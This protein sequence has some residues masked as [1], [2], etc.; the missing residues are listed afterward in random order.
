VT[1]SFS[2]N[3]TATGSSTLTV[4]ASSSASLGQYTV[5]ITGRSGTQTA[6]TTVSLG[7]Y[8]PTFTLYGPGNVTLDQG[9]NTTSYVQVSSEYGFTGSV[10]F[11]ISGLPSGVTASF[12]PNPT[13]TGTSVLTLQANSS[14][15]LGQQHTVTIT[16]TSGGQSAST[17][18]SLAVYAPTFTIYSG[19]NL[20]VGRGTSTASYINIY[21]QYGFTG[22][23]SLAVSGLPSGVTASFSPNPTATGNSSLTVQASSSASLGQYT[24]TITGTS[25]TQTASTTLT[26][27][28]YAPT[29]TLYGPGNAN[30]GRGTPITSNIQ[31]SPEYGFTGNVSLAVSGLPSG[32]TASFSPNPTAIGYSTLTLQASS[33]ASL[34]E[35]IVKITGTSGAQTASTTLALGVYVPTFTFYSVPNVNLSQGTTATSNVY[36]YPEYGFTGNVNFAVAGLPSGVTASFSPNPSATG[37]SVLTFQTNS[38]ASVG[39]YTD[40]L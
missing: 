7:V 5:T 36:I 10:N 2:P 1:A 35:F 33:S 37:T 6:S 11:A 16:G 13:A 39:Q 14:A 32:V 27:A 18:F 15:S 8:A 17:T 24:V 38:I 21:P 12:S 40:T 30:I 34:G 22:N 26:L 31:I 25:G 19:G 28:V 29:F 4:Q 3:P 20:S 23:V 9:T